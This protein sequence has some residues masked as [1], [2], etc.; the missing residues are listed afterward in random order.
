[1]PP[2]PNVIFIVALFS[3]MMAIVVWFVVLWRRETREH[4]LRK[5][6]YEEFR[7]RDEA[8]SRE[9]AD[10]VA[11]SVARQQADQPAVTVPVTP[12]ER[13]DRRRIIRLYD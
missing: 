13:Q 1:M 4:A 6:R 7:R 12:Q 10:I 5:Q 3:G 11:R 2:L 8:F 9:I